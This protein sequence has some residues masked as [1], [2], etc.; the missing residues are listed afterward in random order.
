MNTVQNIFDFLN[1][2]APIE[3]QEGF[4]NSG[5][6]FGNINCE[7]RKVILS[8]DV[9]SDI[10]NEA[11]EEKCNLIISHHPLI[12]DGIQNVFSDD[13]TGNKLIKLAKKDLNVICMHTNLDKK[14]VNKVLIETISDQDFEQE[15]DY[16]WSGN[17]S[18]SKR[19]IDYIKEIKHK[20]SAP[21]V[22]YYDA[23]IPVKKIGCIGGSGGFALEK[24]YS[25]GID[26][27]ITADIK[28]STF[29]TAKE[30]GI[31]LIDAN[32][33]STE[34]VV[35]PELKKILEKEFDDIEFIIAANNIMEIQ[36]A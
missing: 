4:D 19:L 30:L 36:Y 23:G 9:T 3:S 34:N 1:D 7:V 25:K 28:Y 24:A 26:T 6:L 2:Y 31:N 18:E 27:F 8:L 33:F 16:L 5:F 12:F 22:R 35:I 32:H 15:D 29:L 13:P 20:L 21:G 10:I 11:F 14:L 17:L